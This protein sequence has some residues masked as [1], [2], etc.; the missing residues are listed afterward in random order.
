MKKIMMMLM[1]VVMMV[2]IVVVPAFGEVVIKPGNGGEVVVPPATEDFLGT[3]NNTG[4]QPTPVDTSIKIFVNGVKLTPDVPPFID[5]ASRTQ[6]PFRA[7]GEALGCKVTWVNETRQ[8]IVEKVGFKVV[9]VIGQKT[10]TVN[11]QTKTMD[12]APVIKNSRTFIPVRA[13]AEAL[14]CNVT[15]DGTTNTVN[16]TSK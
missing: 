3:G 2:S 5:T 16:V 6:A 8:V 9:M 13:L 1:V 14:D 11:G 15:W 10:F 4:T 7:I 12:T